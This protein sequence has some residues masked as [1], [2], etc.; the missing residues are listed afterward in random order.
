MKLLIAAGADFT[1]KNTSG[2]TAEHFARYSPNRSNIATLYL[3]LARNVRG[4]TEFS[5]WNYLPR[6]E[7]EMK[8]KI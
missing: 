1:I 6:A 7:K 4:E 2:S 8:M 3:H 5:S